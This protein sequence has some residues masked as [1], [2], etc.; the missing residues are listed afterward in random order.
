MSFDPVDFR[1]NLPP[2]LGQGL[3]SADPWQRCHD[4]DLARSLRM[5]TGSE[6]L[7]DVEFHFRKTLRDFVP[8]LLREEACPQCGKLPPF[9]SIFCMWHEKKK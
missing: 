8:L 6:T 5:A 3:P 1:S 2:M 4:Q 9:H 7:R